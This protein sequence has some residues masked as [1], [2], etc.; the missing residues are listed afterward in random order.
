MKF[1][2]LFIIINS[3]FE[4]NIFVNIK[5]LEREK[6][7][8]ILIDGLYIYNSVFS[9]LINNYKFSINEKT[10][11]KD[12]IILESFKE[13]YV[14]CF[15]N[16]KLIIYY[17]NK[18]NFTYLTYNNY[19]QNLKN[20]YNLIL[21]GEQQQQLKFVLIYEK[22]YEYCEYIFWGCNIKKTINFDIEIPNKKGKYEL[23]NKILIDDSIIFDK[24]ICNSYNDFSQ[25]KCF[26]FSECNEIYFYLS[27][28]ILNLNTINL[29]QKINLLKI[30]INS[31]KKI[32]SSISESNKILVCF[33][34]NAQ[35][36]Y[37]Y[38]II[39]N[40]SNNYYVIECT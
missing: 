25:L 30:K 22:E 33:L 36:T 12:S 38:C 35:I 6:Y 39:N 37:S 28:V 29:G 16:N 17:K 34:F 23:K 10:N 27:Y 15:I 20:Y 2:L 13:N 5:K 9:E 14:V 1:I 4:Q 31:L 8:M 11:Y 24:P 7:F 18:N 19:D 3:S 40:W 26:Y 21:F 32:E